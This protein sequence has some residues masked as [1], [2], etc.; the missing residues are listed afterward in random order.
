MR[1]LGDKE[2]KASNQ[3][4]QANNTNNL[5]DFA[6][7]IGKGATQEYE[8]RNKNMHVAEKKVTEVKISYGSKMRAIQNNAVD[9]NMTRENSTRRHFAPHETVHDMTDITVSPR[10]CSRSINSRW[11]V[12]D[13]AP[14][15]ERFSS[16]ISSINST[17]QGMSLSWNSGDK[18]KKFGKVGSSDR[19]TLFDAMKDDTSLCENA[20]TLPK[21]RSDV[22][23]SYGSEVQGHR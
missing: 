22:L 1:S 20:P 10:F 13:L 16:N 15:K 8:D 2:R 5:S 23:E 6:G 3:T 18:F 11:D 4:N 17:L 21:M 14:C 9:D 19:L 12:D 7:H